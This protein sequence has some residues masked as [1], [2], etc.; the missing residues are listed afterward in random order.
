MWGK[1][2]DTIITEDG[3]SFVYNNTLG[4]TWVAIPFNDSARPQGDQ[5]A[6]AERWDYSRNRI[7]GVN[8]GGWLVI[9]PFIA[10]YLFEPFL[11]KEKIPIDE[12]T[13]NQALGTSAA[14][15]IENHYKTFITEID[16]AQIASAGLNWVRIPIGWW[17]IET[18]GDE[19]FLA[20]V[21]WKYLL[22]AFTWAR[23]Y[24]LRIN[25]DLHSVPGSQNGW[26]HSGRQG[27][28]IG[29]LTGAMGIV[30]AQRTCNYIRTLTQFISQPEYRNVVPM[31]SILNEPKV[32]PTAL[33]SWY[34]EVYK[35]IRGI[36]GYGEGNGPFIVLHDAFQG[37]S[38]SGASLK[39]PWAG[40]MNGSDRVGLDNH[41]YL[42]FGPQSTD[43]LDANSIKPCSRWA[44]HQ[45]LTMDVFGL[46][47][48]GEWSLAIND[49][50]LFVNNVG[51]GS[52]FDGT[53]PNATSPDPKN[54]RLGDCTYW[55]DH[56]QW[57][58]QSKASFVDLGLTSQ[59]AL[60]NSFFWTWKIGHSI[61]QENPPNP[62]WNYQLG[63]QAGYIS[64][65]ARTSPGKCEKKAVELGTNINPYPW[66]GTLL[67]WRTGGLG[68]GA[69]KQSDID[70]IG[71]FPPLNIAGSPQDGTRT[72]KSSELPQLAPTGPP[73]VLKPIPL[74]VGG[75]NY[76]TDDGWYRPDDDEG[77]YAPISGCNYLDPWAGGG[78]PAPGACQV[79]SKGASLAPAPTKPTT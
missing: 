36:G 10:P 48:A 53:Y 59:D 77:Y 13:L 76:P 42:S 64:P 14:S 35:M 22:K 63:L 62:M 18:L 65:D 39:T 8:L 50:G 45:N 7:Y 47:V 70:L 19:P 58:P 32:E 67:P 38:G 33:K 23:K 20:G 1:G 74:V 49:C 29:F 72:Y 4:G 44:A 24:G 52:R 51:S 40:F 61:T 66:D 60:I 16:F 15:V 75:R 78:V 30:N 43:S 56:R 12:W 26:N 17:L 68:A 6:L 37:A 71:P 31:F 11:K 69:I 9:E 79:L 3:K 46:A 2:G 41:P 25:L 54:P 28:G 5:P 27:H 21:S 55:N 34:Y 73:I 57:T